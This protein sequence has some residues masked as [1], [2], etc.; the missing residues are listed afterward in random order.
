MS[1]R[2]SKSVLTEE[3][4]KRVYAGFHEHSVS[5]TGIDGL[6]EAPLAFEMHEENHW[7]GCV[8]AQMFW[9]QLHIKYLFVEPLY[10]GRGYGRKLMEYVLEFGKSQGCHFAFVETINFQA[11]EFYQS[12]GFKIDFVRRGYNQDTSF[13]YLTKNLLY[14]PPLEIQVSAL[15]ATDIPTMVEAFQKANWVKPATVFQAYLQEQQD[16][17]RKVWIASHNGQF[18]GYVTLKW[19]SQ[20]ESFRLNNI[21]E[22]MDLNVL[23]HYQRQGIGSRLLEIAENEAFQKS[24]MV[25]LGVGLYKDYGPAQQLYVRRG[26]V[27]DGHGITYKYH[28]ALPGNQYILDDD[29]VLWFTKRLR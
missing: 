6:Q 13:Y 20:Y 8:V 17:R 28:T 23:P 22:I 3:I 21:P 25:G 2:I 19:D 18:V 4:K 26:Y 16:D 24:S 5:S 15:Q 10:R 11:P 1:Y 29:L 9:G 7:V 14:K 12:M 27:P